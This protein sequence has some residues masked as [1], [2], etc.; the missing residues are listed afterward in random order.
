MK[1]SLLDIIKKHH[2]WYSVSYNLNIDDAAKL[3]EIDKEMSDAANLYADN[4]HTDRWQIEVKNDIHDLFTNEPPGTRFNREMAERHTSIVELLISTVKRALINHAFDI[5]QLDRVT[6]W[7]IGEIARGTQIEDGLTR[8]EAKRQLHKISKQGY[9]AQYFP[10]LCSKLYTVFAYKDEAS[11]TMP[12]DTTPAAGQMGEAGQEPKTE[13]PPLPTD[14]PI[15]VL[16]GILDTPRARRVF[17]KAIEKGY[18]KKYFE[19]SFE[20]IGVTNRGRNVQFAYLCGKIYG[21]NYSEKHHGNIGIQFPE[22]ELKE[23]INFDNLQQLL[24]N[25]YD[26]PAIKRQKWLDSIDALFE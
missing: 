12:K 23:L 13:T 10:E 18:M 20:W 5:S 22:Q 15:G 25:F 7:R 17:G 14:L 19:G 26:R 6:Q 1:E 21:Y 11:Q 2:N 8:D 9:K 3:T 24:F 16:P 4:L